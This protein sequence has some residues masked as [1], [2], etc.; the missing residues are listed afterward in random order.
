[1]MKKR[2]PENIVN[3]SSA[4]ETVEQIHI[5][6]IGEAMIAFKQISP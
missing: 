6:E 3:G 4:I 2:W 1:M 5:V